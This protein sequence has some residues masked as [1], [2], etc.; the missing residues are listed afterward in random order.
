MDG[1]L[2]YHWIPQSLPMLNLQMVSATR[3]I[4]KEQSR[5]LHSIDVKKRVVI[6]FLINHVQKTYLFF[7]TNY[8]SGNLLAYSTYKVALNSFSMH[9]VFIFY[10][11]L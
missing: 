1:P 6:H 10:Y 2:W 7:K 5:F 9:F 4:L 3:A 11:G 8:L